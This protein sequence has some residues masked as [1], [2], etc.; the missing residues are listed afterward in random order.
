MS[1][2]KLIKQELHFAVKR[3]KKI[4]NIIN[5]FK[6]IRDNTI[7]LSLPNATLYNNVYCQLRYRQPKKVEIIT[8]KDNQFWRCP[9]CECNVQQKGYIYY[10][11]F[12]GQALITPLNGCE[13]D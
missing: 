8:V 9:T 5:K 1:N 4:K 7:D 2:I 13:E 10:C 11:D 12:C 3:Q 6:K